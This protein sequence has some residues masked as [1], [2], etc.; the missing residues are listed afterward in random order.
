[1]ARSL[2]PDVQNK[3]EKLYAEGY[4]KAEIARRAG[5]HY[6]TVCRL[7][8]NGQ[9][10]ET[11]LTPEARRALNDFGYY[12][13]RY[14][15]RISLPWHTQL[16][17]KIVEL[18]ATTEREYLVVNVP[19]GAG[20]STTL[21]DLCCW[22]L[23]RDRT[24]RI[25]YGSA[26][27]TVASDYTR[28]IMN[29]LTRPDPW[30]ASSKDLELG[31]AVDAESTLEKDFGKFKPANGDRWTKEKFVIA[32][33]AGRT[34]QEKEASVVAYGFDSQ[35]LGG[36]FD[37]SLWDDLVTEKNIRT[38]D[39]RNRLFQW[40]ENTAETRCEPG[41]LVVLN[42]Q[43]LG[44]H[45]LY[46]YT[47]DMIGETA[48]LHVL[49]DPDVSDTAPRKYHHVMFP[50]H[51]EDT[52]KGPTITLKGKEIPNPDHQVTAQPWPAGCLLDPKRLSWRFLA[53]I[54]ANR[55]E[56]FEIVYQQKDTDPVNALVRHE[57]IDGGLGPD[58]IEHPGC[59]SQRH[60][61]Q[62]PPSLGP[63]WSVITVDPSPTKYWG[64][65]WWL[66]DDTTDRWILMDLVR[67]KMDAP[68]WL[69]YHIDT[70]EFT[71]IAEEWV[72]RSKELGRPITDVIVEI[73]AAQKFMHQYDYTKR[74]ASTRSVT[75]RG[76]QTNVNKGDSEY[77]IQMLAPLYRHGRV[78]LP[79]GSNEARNL[80]RLLIKEVTQWPM[81][82]TDDLVMSHWFGAF[83]ASRVY[84]AS[85]QVIQFRRP[86]WLRSA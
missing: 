36:R 56:K 66:Y 44:P 80:S 69:D 16:A 78:D 49:D 43:R 83:T 63:C 30:K 25:L 24:T 54:K 10:D 61:A 55:G 2:P 13:R 38:E 7:L 65:I 6:N 76:H 31:L 26:V 42:G 29:D 8:K 23:T 70:G 18:L 45:D 9:R 5:V 34:A 12:R 75:I 21:T 33:E 37:L 35:F 74:W 48:E 46:R 73:N 71:G 51:A 86:S 50:A 14:M 17:S 52:C 3:I 60:I 64:I 27:E 81:G 47:L 22:A 20:K 84:N 28:R 15:G 32:Q 58:G 39:G 59:L 82:T 41:G 67:A 57:W 53:P 19:P 40:W 77:G 11:Q 68:D 1:M 72:Q 85:P 4:N 62:A 79:W